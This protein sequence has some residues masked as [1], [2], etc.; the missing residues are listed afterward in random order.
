MVIEVR[1]IH[2]SFDSLEVIRG[3]SLEVRRGEVMSIVGPS[4]AGKSTLLQK[5]GPLDRPDSGQVIYD[6]EDVLRLNERRL[7][8]FRNRR[9]GFVFQFHQLLPE[10]TMLENV[11]M[12]ALIGGE[13]REAAFAR[14]LELIE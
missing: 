4:G 3:V 8:R 10:F 13:S 6:G 2:K 1:D 5:M 7:A 12:P 11:A 9:I 14:A